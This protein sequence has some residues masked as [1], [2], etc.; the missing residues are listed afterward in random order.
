MNPLEL[1]LTLINRGCHRGTIFSGR[2]VAGEGGGALGLISPRG[3]NRKVIKRFAAGCWW[4]GTSW[5]ITDNT[6]DPV[7][8]DSQTCQRCLTMFTVYH[9]VKPLASSHLRILD[10]CHWCLK[11][12]EKV[13][14]FVDKWPNFRWKTKCLNAPSNSVLIYNL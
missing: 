13:N 1:T 11:P 6:M 7:C 14:I 9:V 12:V 5:G 3:Q 2:G 10:T 4:H 8:M